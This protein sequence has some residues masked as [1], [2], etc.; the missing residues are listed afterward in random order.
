MKILALY[1][2]SRIGNSDF[3]TDSVLEGI[4]CTKIY[5]REKNILPID[6][7][8]H[9]DQGFLPVSDDCDE[10]IAEMLQHDIVI[11]ATP[12]YWYGMSG[13]MKNFVDRWSQFL[14]DSRYNFKQDMIGKQGYVLITGGDL[15]RVKGLPLIQQFQYIFDFVEMSF[16]GY[17]IGEGN[18]PDDIKTDKAA[19]FEAQQLNHHLKTLLK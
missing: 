13:I 11:F 15:P 4:E 19:L 14:R 9:S 5:L 2:S 10:V 18:K 3:L 6:D 7:G 1:G 17:I 12:I 8:R 16:K